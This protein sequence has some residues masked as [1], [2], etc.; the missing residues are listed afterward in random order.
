MQ[1]VWGQDECELSTLLLLSRC[2][3]SKTTVHTC[4]RSRDRCEK[5]LE[6]Q[7]SSQGNEVQKSQ[8]WLL[9][10]PIQLMVWSPAAGATPAWSQEVLVSLQQSGLEAEGT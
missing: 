4:L 6:A 1:R 8:D 2:P 9:L 7:H 3:H 10:L 5:A